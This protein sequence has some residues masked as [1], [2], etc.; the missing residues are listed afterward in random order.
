MDSR[1]RLHVGQ[2]AAQHNLASSAQKGTVEDAIVHYKQAL[3]INPDYAEAHNN[4]G[5]ALFQSGSVDE[6]I[7]HFH[8]R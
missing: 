8:R 1:A 7:V 4:L 2:R 3:Q 6:A 5:V